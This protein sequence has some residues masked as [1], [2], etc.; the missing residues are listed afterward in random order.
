MIPTTFLPLISCEFFSQ[1]LLS[2]SKLDL[3]NLP[4][5]SPSPEELQ[6]IVTKH[7]CFSILKI[8][9]SCQ[10]SAK[11]FTMEECRA[12]FEKVIETCFGCEIVEQVFDRYANK[13]IGKPLLT[14]DDGLG[15][16]LFVLLK[17]K[18]FNLTDAESSNSL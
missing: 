14:A 3:F 18:V 10:K 5:Y 15:I 4:M 6:K 11:L 8:E 1:R 13:I 7:G 17:F 16:N 12:G 9:H 2:E